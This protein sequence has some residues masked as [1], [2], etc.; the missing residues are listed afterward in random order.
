MS[1]SQTE[2]TGLAPGSNFPDGK[3]H[4]L[5]KLAGP[6]Q[7]PQAKRGPGKDPQTPFSPG[8]RATW[9]S[10]SSISAAAP[11]RR[12]TCSSLKGI[13]RALQPG[14]CL[15]VAPGA[16]LCVEGS[17]VKQDTGLLQQQVLLADRNPGEGV[18]PI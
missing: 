2:T 4:Q 12:R 7:A 13:H 6:F 8:T 18:I 11:P 14:F 10:Q 5:W 17:D 9:Q 3:S 15:P 1:H 16:D